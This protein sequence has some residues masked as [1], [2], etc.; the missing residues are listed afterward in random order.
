M[1][2][3]HRLHRTFAVEINIS[4]D[5]V[6]KVQ[7]YLEKNVSPRR[8]YLHNQIGGQNWAIKTI[9]GENILCVNDEQLATYI[10]LA[11]L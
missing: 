6:A 9:A 1:M 4:N 3:I 5:I 11:I 2:S 8:Y 10:A 7:A